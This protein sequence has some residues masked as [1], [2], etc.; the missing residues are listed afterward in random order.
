[1]WLTILPAEQIND[2]AAL[3]V[4]S[5]GVCVGL[6]DLSSGAAD[7]VIS[8]GGELGKLVDLVR[9]ARKTV[10]VAKF[11]ARSGMTVSAVQMV[12]AAFGM[13]PPYANAIIQEVVD[14][15]AILNGLRM[16]AS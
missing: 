6:N 2:A 13:I 4:A 1:M 10:S 14:L 8:S 12:L 9:L 3:A 11:G 7:V 5:V 16:L 15:S